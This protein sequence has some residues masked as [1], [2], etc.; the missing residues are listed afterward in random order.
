[1]TSCKVITRDDIENT[2]LDIQKEKGFDYSNHPNK[3][4]T[5]DVFANLR[6]SYK[7]CDGPTNVIFTSIK[8]QIR[9]SDRLNKS[10]VITS[11]LDGRYSGYKESI[12]DLQDNISAAKEDFIPKLIAERQDLPV[13]GDER[14]E[15]DRTIAEWTGATDDLIDEFIKHNNEGIDELRNMLKNPIT[16]KVR[17]YSSD[18]PV[19]VEEKTTNYVLEEYKFLADYYLDS[20]VEA[21]I[22]DLCKKYENK[23]DQLVID[24][25][26]ENNVVN[27]NSDFIDRVNQVEGDDKEELDLIMKNLPTMING[28]WEEQKRIVFNNSKYNTE[29]AMKNIEKNMKQTGLKTANPTKF[30]QIYNQIYCDI[31][32]KIGLY[33]QF[34]EKYESYKKTLEK[35]KAPEDKKEMF[36]K[37]YDTRIKEINDI[38]EELKGHQKEIEKEDNIKPNCKGNTGSSM[39]NMATGMFSKIFSRKKAATQ[40]AGKRKQRRT[41]TNKLRTHNNNK[42]TKHSRKVKRTTNKNNRVKHSKKTKK[43]RKSRNARKTRKH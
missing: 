43:A 30:H 12:K 7:L 40:A 25:V 32:T 11:I 26:S 20:A 22:K 9:E 23:I 29:H 31:E 18:E 38:I 35:I 42:R 14:T 24:N 33:K 34:K 16:T 6:S 4:T 27:F 36:T 19:S 8:D 3:V 2:Y 41:K 37:H 17:E 13:L 21:K 10:N 39:K 1:M 5:S 28:S 15:Y